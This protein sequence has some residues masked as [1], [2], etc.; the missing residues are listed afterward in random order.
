MAAIT[1]KESDDIPGILMPFRLSSWEPAS[2]TTHFANAKGES[3]IRMGHAGRTLQF[4]VLIH[5]GFDQN[6]LTTF[7]SK[8]TD[9]VNE[10]MTL[11]IDGWNEFPNC[12]FKQFIQL[13]G[14]LEDIAET[15]D[16][17]GWWVE[18]VLE[19]R[20]QAPKA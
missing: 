13:R 4:H 11:T 9:R 19:F 12:T 18:G 2:R 5:D 1:I 14:Q 6:A 16:G 10:S 3:E 15:L 7:L 8:L 20:Q 17:G